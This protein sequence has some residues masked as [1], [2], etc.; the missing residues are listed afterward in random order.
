MTA[1]ALTKVVAVAGAAA[2]PVLRRWGAEAV[3]LADS[4]D[5][6]RLPARAPA[7]H[8][9]AARDHAAPVGA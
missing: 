6:R 4:G 1:D 9:R 8:R 7:A 5:W 3:L 2:L